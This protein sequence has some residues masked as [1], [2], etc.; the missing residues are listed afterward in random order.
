MPAHLPALAPRPGR[1]ALV[2]G[3]GVVGAAAVLLGSA[4]ATASAAPGDTSADTTIA[5]VGVTSTIS[6]N[7]LTPSFQ[8]NGQPG[9]TITENGAV[10]MNVGTNN[11][12]GYRVTVQ[13]ADDAL[14]PGDTT[15]NPDSIPIANL[16]VRESAPGDNGAW[17]SLSDT[18]PVTVH[19]QNTRSVQAGDAVSNDYQ[20]DIPFVNA[21]TYSVV[22]DY[23]ATAL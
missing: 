12:G 11:T 15:A 19:Q 22:L 5:N 10:A 9:A 13:A 17:V 16:R 23:V 3:L 6:L 8:L 1:R 7:G 14:L 4:A 20:V 2:R 21:D 18:S